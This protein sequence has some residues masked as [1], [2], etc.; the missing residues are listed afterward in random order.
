MSRFQQRITWVLNLV[1]LVGYLY[2]YRFNGSDI[3]EIFTG[4]LYIWFISWVGFWLYIWILNGRRKDKE[5][6]TPREIKIRR[7]KDTGEKRK[8]N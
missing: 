1:W 5:L 8:T 6:G 3:I 2:R 4:L 7:K